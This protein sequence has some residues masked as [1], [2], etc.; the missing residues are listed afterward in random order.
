MYAQR[1]PLYIRG[2]KT[3]PFRARMKNGR[4]VFRSKRPRALAHGASFF[5][6]FFLLLCVF[7]FVGCGKWEE[8]QNI[9][10]E[11]TIGIKEQEPLPQDQINI[12]VGSMITPKEGYAH[13][14]AL[15]DYLSNSL[16]MKVNFIDKESYD[17]VNTLLK[18]G[19]IDV[20]FVCGG[21][22]I[23]GHTDFG[24]ELLVAPQVNGKSEYHSYII[25]HRDSDITDFQELRGRSFVFVDPLSNT[26]KLYP[27]FLLRQID[28]TPEIFF[29]EY[30]Y[31]YAHDTSIR[32]VSEGI[33]D[34]AAVD[35]LIWNY[36]ERRGSPFT[37]NT[38]II[39]ISPAYG[40]PPVVVRPDLGKELK[41]RIRDILLKMHQDNK[42]RVILENMAIEKFVP[43]ED[44]N[45]DTIREIKACL[46][47]K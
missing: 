26:G 40:I 21:P 18:E 20:A 30:I 6:L 1:F 41:E 23:E 36:M 37:K 34:A 33:A 24:L 19:K 28:E 45:Y 9:S 25:V 2:Q 29:K 16:K 10:F 3:L 38:R 14:K 13:Y 32:A 46:K 17:E 39:N 4:S 5:V 7:L 11:D 47:N 42:G 44:S 8:L 12:C 43:I 27:A 22:Y 15:L 31:S 35:S